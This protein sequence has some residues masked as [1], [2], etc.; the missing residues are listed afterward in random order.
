[1]KKIIF[2]TLMIAV[3]LSVSA[4]LPESAGRKLTVMVYM[5]GSN[6][7]TYYGSASKDLKEMMDADAGEDICVLAM[8]GGSEFW[9]LDYDTEYT[10]IVEIGAG[11]QHTVCTFEKTNMGEADT[12]TRL[13]TWAQKNRPA[14]DY[15]LIMW[16]H[17]A[18]PLEG[19]CWDEL[20][21]MDHL[22]LK[23]LTDGI[24]D[25]WLYRKLSWIGFDACLM[26]SAEVAAAVAPYAEYMIASE[27]TEPAAGWNYA[28]LRDADGDGAATGRR[29]VDSYFE[30]L[31]DSRDPLTLSCID[32]SAIGNV[33]AAME[34]F[35]QP[36]DEGI[37]EEQFADISRIRSASSGFGKGVRAVGEEGYD[38]VDLADL[39]ARYGG[40]GSELDIA[41]K[42]AV[43]YVRSDSGKAGGLSVYHPYINMRKYLENWRDEYR[44][45]DFSA[46]YTRYIEHF[47]ALLAGED[48]V[49]WS[50]MTATD[51]TDPV[52]GEHT[53]RLQL[54]EAQAKNYLN[55]EM[56]IMARIGSGSQGLSLA[57][58]AVARA[59]LDEA[60]RLSAVYRGNALYAVSE[61]GE[62]LQG[63]VSFRITEDGD[64]HVIL[65]VYQDYSSRANTRDETAVLYYCTPSGDG[66]DLEIDRT[67]V[68]DRATQSYTNRIP[69]TDEGFTDVEFRYFIRNLPDTGKA[70][71]EFEE[72]ELYRGYLARAITLP[73]DWHLRFLE[74]WNT[75][76]LYA[77]FQITD[78]HQKRWSSI[79]L[80]IASPHV[81]D[82][83][84]EENILKTEG[85][86]IHCSAELKATQLY[87]SLKFR[88]QFRNN[89]DRALKF[90]GTNAVLN[91]TRSTGE[92]V[93]ISKAEPG[94][95]EEDTITLDAKTIAGLERITSLDF[96]VEVTEYGDYHSE[97]VVIPVHLEMN[98]EPGPLASEAPDPLDTVQDGKITWQLVSMRQEPDG[99]VSGMIHVINGGDTELNLSGMLLVNRMQTGCEI[100]VRV[101]PGTDAYI[102][103]EAEDRETVSSF[104]LNISESNH[105]FLMGVNQ[106]LEQAGYT[107]ADRV[108][109]Y[110]GMNYYGDSGMAGQITLRLPE[111]IP[112]QQA[113]EMPDPVTIFDYNGI[114]VSAEQ[115]LIADDGI[116]LGLRLENGT[117][118][119]VFL[120]TA[121]PAVNG[122]EYDGFNPYAGIRMP[123]HT[124]A[125]HC[126][127][128][129][130]RDG[131]HPGDAAGELTFR[132]RIGNQLSSPVR[133]GFPAG[134]AFGA[135][136]GTLLYAGVCAVTA[137]VM[138]DK[139]MA[140]NETVSVT[141][142]EVRQF[143]ITAP[144]TAEEAGTLERGNVGVCVLSYERS[145][146]AG[147]PEQLTMRLLTRSG[148]QRDGDEWT[149]RLS[150]LAVTI[151]GY[152]LMTFETQLAESIWQLDPDSIYF[153]TEAGSFRP[154]ASS[155]SL[156]FRE[157]INLYSNIRLTVENAS[158][159]AAVRD[160]QTELRSWTYSKDPRTNRYLDEI[161]EAAVE[162][163]VFFGSNRPVNADTIDYYEENML[164]LNK[165]VTPELIPIGQIEGRK[166][167][168]FTLFFMDGTRKDI[169]QDPESGEILDQTVTPL[170][171]PEP[172]K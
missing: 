22:T 137:A 15:A 123:P 32:L 27:E 71:P 144:L 30:A 127:V 104:S 7:E 94:G 51:E 110:P 57:P 164:Q 68:Y 120:E 161:A 45:L 21:S 9:D 83:E 35:F 96:S 64:Y 159:R 70:I 131:I 82:L 97:P 112:L 25:A 158:G 109:I 133:I 74:E 26:G 129:S 134:T 98:A 88:V 36:I 65:T 29:I 37:N 102:P 55:G 78:I 39:A 10:H 165:Q 121:G 135:E 75:D 91:G 46:A 33:I 50:S 93:W 63:P 156:L 86:E 103:F 80:L 69:F 8:V 92:S 67:Y 11:E 76:A 106:A 122:K 118:E 111:G 151:Q 19:I 125:V 85:I 107:I 16:N 172:G 99:L 79:P 40:E 171:E 12:L 100:R 105:L 143:R 141:D 17:G 4:A 168:Y 147:T 138:E 119:T 44:Q 166:C 5:C 114:R 139:P 49:D 124:R 155:R 62:V 72:W 24:R 3:L 142:E 87:P 42:K 77:V 116:G 41:L 152:P 95:T 53:V 61:E 140:L 167:L 169:I 73:R 136:G 117:D 84:V 89:T 145:P 59:S 154:E 113:E 128:L 20:F 1:M 28:F 132:F 148:L 130:D 13:L 2:L 52:T 157:G 6:L 153:Y 60:G 56:L 47:G 66:R 150:G 54:T 115:F 163:R 58:V 23:E 170:A 38:L 90:T 81:A 31:A 101:E 149:A 126:L 34:S 43:V 160:Q 108:D 18:G 146:L 48:Y 162:Q 14:E